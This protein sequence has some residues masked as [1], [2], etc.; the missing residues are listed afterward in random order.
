[1]I[2]SACREKNMKEMRP[3]SRQVEP[4]CGMVI[5]FSMNDHRIVS[6]VCG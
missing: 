1:M 3:D 5:M 2:L 6:I 4:A